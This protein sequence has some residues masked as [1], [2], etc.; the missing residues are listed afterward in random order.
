MTARKTTPATRSPAQ[1]EA[2][3]G[4]TRFEWEG[5]EVTIP[6]DMDD[7]PTLVI[8]KFQRGQ[9][10]DAVELLFG[11]EKWTEF[12]VLHPSRREFNDMMTALNKHV[13][14]ESGN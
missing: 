2:E 1:V 13:G 8:Q 3:G 6:T 11:R 12:N 14:I 4:D 7:W 5:F 9:N 10:I